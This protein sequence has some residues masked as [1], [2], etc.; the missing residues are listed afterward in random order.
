MLFAPEAVVEALAPL[1]SMLFAPEAV[2]ENCRPLF[3]VL[4]GLYSSRGG[5]RPAPSLFGERPLEALELLGA[6]G[7]C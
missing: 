2:D 3:G 4:P 1:T 7:D 6:R 5:G